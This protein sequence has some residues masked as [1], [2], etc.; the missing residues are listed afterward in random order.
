MAIA[1]LL[2]DFSA[3]RAAGASRLVSEDEWQDHRLAAFEQ[4]YSAGWEDAVQAQVR[5]HRRL[6]EA[7]ARNLE[8]MSFGYHEALAQMVAA[9]APVLRAIIDRVL[10]EAMALSFGQHIVDEL[11]GLAADAAGR[12]AVV[13]VPAGAAA[14]VAPMLQRDFA[15]PVALVEDPALDPGQA[16]IRLGDSG[17]DID[18]DRLLASIRATIEA[19]LFHATEETR[20]G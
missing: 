13:A 8:D 12:P 3:V 10:P 16:Q 20:H 15:M 7:L 2:E 1:H 11:L 6:S 17:R 5:E 14:L 18:C 19:F 4:G 9:L